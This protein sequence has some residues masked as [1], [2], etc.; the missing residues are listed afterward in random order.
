MN[1]SLK[2]VLTAI[3]LPWLVAYK[4]FLGMKK[5][6]SEKILFFSFPDFADNAKALYEFMRNEP[7]YEKYDFV[8]LIKDEKEMKRDLPRTS[9]VRL[10]SDLH[11]GIG[12]SAMKA[13]SESGMIFYTHTSPLRYVSEK[14]GQVIV[15][16]WHGC[17]YKARKTPIPKKKQFDYGLV[18]GE[19][20]I[21]VKAKFWG[22]KA[23]QVLPIGYPRYDQ[24]IHPSKEASD[25]AAEIKG[26]QKKLVLWMPTYRKTERNEFAVSKIKG[27]YEIPGLSDERELAELDDFCKDSGIRL[28]IKR[29]PKQVRYACEMR[30]FSNI[31]F[32]SHQDLEARGIDLYGLMAHADALITDY[33]SSAIDYLLLD[34]PLAFAVNDM[35]DYGAAQGFVFQDPLK[36]MPGEHL[37]S[38][39]DFMG[40]LED[41]KSERDPHAQERKEVYAVTHCPCDGYCERICKYFGL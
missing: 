41:L 25:F 31:T 23:E 29:H 12:T 24:L 5:P 33:S 15:N 3:C 38:L 28:C 17:G 20:F 35:E 22:C 36:Y 39:R 13:I 8:W 32:L 18:P 1:K 27:Y 21:P 4:L 14:K 10:G 34:R 19:L 2:Y 7:Q 26:E 16:L 6:R 40:F 37:K 11:F 30:D 9:F